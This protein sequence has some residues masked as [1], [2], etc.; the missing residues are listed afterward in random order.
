MRI[1]AVHQSSEL[2]GSDRSFLAAIQGLLAEVS[3]VQEVTVVLPDAGPLSDRLKDL[4]LSLHYE[5]RGYLR[6]TEL[7]APLRYLAN[8][9]GGIRSLK[10]KLGSADLIY[11]NT[12]VCLSAI[13]L[14]AISSN[15]LIVHVREIP[16]ARELFFFRWLLKMSRAEIIYN[17]EATGSAVGLPGV[18]VY[19]GVDAPEDTARSSLTNHAEARSEREGLKLLMLGRINAWKGQEILVS[20][21]RST[22]RETTLRIVGSAIPAQVHLENEL[23][24]LSTE[25]PPNV[26]VE[27][28]AFCD[29]PSLH[30]HW[31]DYVVVP[32]SQPEPFGRVAIEG[33]SSGKPVIGSA[34]GGLVEIVRPGE[35]G[36][37]FKPGCPDSLSALISLLP[38]AGSDEYLRL[39]TNASHDYARRFSTDSYV[40]ALANVFL[41]RSSEQ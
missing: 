21:L 13:L 31:C 18:V 40:K 8:V 29:D 39:S 9:I 16:R 35:T 15:R 41:Q 27:F 25:L 10:K 14:G 3:S 19:N 37:L 7:R 5:P 32:S 28:H 38:V 33:M 4:G 2:Y 12:L 36:F 11:V 6:R 24:A 34:H 22:G 26:R 17:S 1:L 23:R 20:A 30:L